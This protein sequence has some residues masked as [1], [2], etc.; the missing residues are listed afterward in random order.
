MKK[1]LSNLIK[2][3]VI[4]IILSLFTLPA[5][6]N[7]PPPPPM[8]WFVFSYPSGQKTL[9]GLQ[10]VECN[11]ATCEQPTLLI[12]YGECR[13]KACLEPNAITAQTRNTYRFGC[14]ENRCLL[15][16]TVNT[17]GNQQNQ[18]KE[19]SKQWFRLIGQFSDRLRLSNPVLK[20]P[21]GQSTFFP[22]SGLW[23]VQI[24]NDSLQIIQEEDR[25]LYPLFTPLQEYTHQMFLTGWL[26]TI[27]SELLIA[28]PFLWWQK[29]PK[30][31]FWRTLTAIAVV[32]LFSYPVVWSFFPS[33]EAF[34]L[35]L[36][37]YLGI[38]SLI[39]AILYGLIIYN[40]RRDSSRR[41]ILVSILAFIVLNIIGIFGA[42]WF[43]YGNRF[44]IV[45]GIPY[46]LTM[47]ASEVFAIVYEAWL[48][49]TLSLEKLPIR[50]SLLLS[51]LTN[52]TSLIGGFIVF[53]MS[54]LA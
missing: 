19:Q 32:N 6:A 23:Q 51:L 9:Q 17:Y 41:I 39:I 7:A 52:A 1:K 37:R 33:L 27:V 4:L 43:G 21:Q 35:L 47:P 10:I 14:A 26:L 12:Q 24:T 3:L 54:F 28:A 45:T 13:D 46:R 40:R 2:I 8:N 53:G 50:Q 11:T 48:I 44:P 22:L 49:S 15:L 25:Y 30:P 31:K 20:D 34:Q 16:D 38:S 29:T 42:L 5:I 18:A 36:G